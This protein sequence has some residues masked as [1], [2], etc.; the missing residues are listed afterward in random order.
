MIGNSVVPG[1]PNRWVMPSSFK[2]ARNAERPV[3]RFFINPPSSPA[4]LPSRDRPSCRS[5]ARDQW[6]SLMAEMH[7]FASRARVQSS[8]LLARELEGILTCRAAL[9]LGALPDHARISF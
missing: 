5:D 3:M 9:L 6:R 2:S 7:A 4:L 8:H 1:L